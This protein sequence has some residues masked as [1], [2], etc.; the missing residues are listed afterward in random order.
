MKSTALARRLGTAALSAVVVATSATLPAAADDGT[1]L[2]ETESATT[3][4]AWY[5]EDAT[6]AVMSAAELSSLMPTTYAAGET[7]TA[8]SPSGVA[9]AVVSS[10]ASDGTVD[11]PQGAGGPVN[12]GGI[13]NLANSNGAH[14]RIGIAWAVFDDGGTLAET[15]AGTG[16][17]ADAAQAGP[18]R[19]AKKS[20]VPPVAYSGDDWTAVAT[21]ATLPAATVTFTPPEGSGLEATTWDDLSGGNGARAFTFNA[22]GVWTVTLTFANNT[23]RTAHINIQTAG[24]VLIVK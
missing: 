21:S 11:L 7:V 9:T 10:P 17:I 14:A 3:F 23:T 15:A 24:F 19:K 18:D 22:R 5:R 12:A 4:R 8:T 1:L 16:F 20:E 6:Y 2:A 13:W